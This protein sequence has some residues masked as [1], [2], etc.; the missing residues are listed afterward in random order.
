[1][2]FDEVIKMIGVL[3]FPSQ[4]SM[5]QVT[6][7]FHNNCNI[8]DPILYMI[9]GNSQFNITKRGN[10][11]FTSG[12]EGH[13]QKSQKLHISVYGN[14]SYAVSPARFRF[15]PLLHHCYF[16]TLMCAAAGVLISLQVAGYRR[17]M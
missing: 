8:K 15:R 14:G 13:C 2:L 12:V 7:Q 17:I 11:Y 16:P 4:D 5:I 9:N 3:Q 1:M 10:F 6:Q